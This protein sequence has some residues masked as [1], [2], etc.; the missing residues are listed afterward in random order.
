MRR[1]IMLTIGKETISRLSFSRGVLG[2]RIRSLLLPVLMLVCVF[3]AACGAGAKPQNTTVRVQP[4]PIPTALTPKDGN[5]PSRGKV[6]KIN[7]E[8]GSVELDHEDIPTVMPPMRMEFYVRNKEELKPLK[9]GDQVDFI[10]EYKDHRE[11][12][13]TIKKSK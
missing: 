12:I 9:V 6:T 3:L 2:R 8:L 5:Y 13:V 1:S 11:T 4:T 10:L 7:N